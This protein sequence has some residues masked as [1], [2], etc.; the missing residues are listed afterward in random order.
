MDKKLKTQLWNTLVGQAAPLSQPLRKVVGSTV[1]N[2]KAEFMEIPLTKSG[3]YSEDGGLLLATARLTE[4]VSNANITL[5]LNSD[6]LVA[7]SILYYI[8]T[9]DIR[10]LEQESIT[11]S[12]TMGIHSVMLVNRQ[13]EELNTCVEDFQ[14][15]TNK[16]VI[17]D[18]LSILA[19]VDNLDNSAES[20]EKKTLRHLDSLIRTI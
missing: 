13:I 8:G 16:Q 6:L 3:I 15:N 4:M 5:N 2:H 20:Q 11:D 14:I 1:T 10:N 7:S 17:Y 18:L 9:V 12:L 19:S